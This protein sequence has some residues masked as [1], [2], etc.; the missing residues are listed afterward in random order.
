MRYLWC[1]LLVFLPAP[2]AA[3][4]IVIIGDSLM[5]WNEER[6][7]PALLSR[8][9]GVP[10][11]NRSIA[12]AEIS[13]GFWNRW[14]GLDIRAQL[15]S[16]RPSLLVMAGGGNDLADACGCAENCGAEVEVLL[17]QDGQG[18]LGN[19]LRDAVE[20]GTQ[21]FYLGYA[22]PPSGGNEF[23][24]CAP[25][26]H[27]LAERLETMPGVTYVSVSDAINSNDLTLYD[28]DRVHPSAK[29]SSVMATLL[30]E[31]IREL[32]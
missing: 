14:D 29:G 26:F 10:V 21:I 27:T 18:E 19:F 11:D 32:P 25:A 24:S 23:S 13:A 16:D 4:D 8:E 5:D 20:G 17:T 31:S 30:A 9:L 15:G 28:T 12:G 6:S 22:D 3:Q 7:I 1:A 2:V